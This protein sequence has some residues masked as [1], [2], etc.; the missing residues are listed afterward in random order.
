MRKIGAFLVIMILLPCVITVFMSGIDRGSKQGA[1]EQQVKVKRDTKESEDKFSRD[2]DEDYEFVLWEDYLL[3]ILAANIPV[4]YELEAMKAQAVLLR[5]QAAMELAGKTD[6]ADKQLPVPDEQVT[7][8]ETD[9]VL[10]GNYL[11]MEDMKSHWN[12]DELK[13]HMKKYKKAMQ[14][15]K[16]EVLI[17]QEGIAYTPFHNLSTGATRNGAE[18]LES[19]AYP[20]LISVDCSADKE[21]K[22]AMQMFTFSYEEVKAKCQPFLVAVEKDEADKEF[23]FADFEITETDAAGYVMTLNIAGNA[24]QGE[25]FRQ[26]LHLPSSAFVLQDYKGEL[27]ITTTGRGHGI[28]MSQWTANEMAKEGASYSEILSYFFPETT[29][30]KDDEIFLKLE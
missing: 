14:E 12:A 7:M 11:T 17:F 27:R 20:Y 1:K 10:S 18:V 8:P 26:A 6:D 9:A 5:S 21:A 19:D 2:K 30:Q 28:G 24:Y 4:D 15:T 13:K 22:D 25:Q 29:I 16:R 23:V 3:G